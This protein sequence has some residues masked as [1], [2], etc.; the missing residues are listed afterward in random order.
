LILFLRRLMVLSVVSLTCP[1]FLTQND[2]TLTTASAAIRLPIRTFASGQTNSM[3]GASYLAGIG[4]QAQEYSGNVIVIDIGGHSLLSNPLALSQS[5]TL[6]A[7]TKGTTT[8][9]GV[10]L[11]SGLSR[12][13]SRS[14]Y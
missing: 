12:L 10:L 6:S 5:L 8:D 7:I 4:K 14:G 2:G 13:R 11:P 1:L 9:L 3:R